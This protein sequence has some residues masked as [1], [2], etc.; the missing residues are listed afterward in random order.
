MKKKVLYWSPFL[1]NVGTV[2][3]TLNSA[4]ALSKYS[5]NDL[6]VGLINVCGEWDNFHHEIS[7]NNIRLIK[8]NF[9][10]FTYLPKSGYFQSRLSYIIIFLL[11]FFPLIKLFYKYKPDYLII[12]LITSLPLFVNYFLRPKSKLILRI[13]G[14]PKLNPLRKL[15]WKITTNQIYKI[16]CPSLELLDNIKKKNFLTESKILFLPDAIINI[17]K[18]I[19]LKDIKIQKKNNRNYFL[20]VGRFTKQKNFK[21]LINETSKF[22]NKNKNFD[23]YIVGD[24]EEKKDLQ[25]L[26][27]S[28]NL[29]NRIFLI[30]YTNNVYSYMK[31]ASL[32]ILSSLWEDPGF[33]IIEAALCNLSIVSSNCSNGPKEFLSNGKAGNLFNSNEADALYNALKGVNYN[34]F[35]KKVKAKKNSLKYTNYR[36][37]KR[38]NSILFTN[39]I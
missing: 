26:I 10:Y 35:N 13:S 5:S 8:L 12:H 17:K 18:F 11:S 16:T 31:N 39:C 33:V 24:G 20:A 7:N 30:N 2:K 3:S 25:D 32:F 37:F 14:L 1:S 29:N 38:L 21:Y 4:M 34:D 9:S 28:K 27:Y 36:H 22:F 6:D 15:L 23:L 19:K